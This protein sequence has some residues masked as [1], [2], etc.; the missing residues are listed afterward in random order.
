MWLIYVLDNSSIWGCLV[1]FNIGC[2]VW[3]QV[4]AVY[5]EMILSRCTP[6]RK[7]RAMLRSALKYMKQTLRWWMIWFESYHIAKF[8]CVLL[9][10]LD[11][12]RSHMKVRPKLYIDIFF[13][14]FSSLGS[15]R[16]VRP[17]PRIYT[18]K[19]EFKFHECQHLQT[20][21]F[22]YVWWFCRNQDLGWPSCNG[23]QPQGRSCSRVWEERDLPHPLNKH[24]NSWRNNPLH[25]NIIIV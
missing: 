9:I 24:E 22:L 5:E 23:I 16:K 13:S 12:V 10:M 21:L 20:F 19:H 17:K 1:Y 7:A 18:H 6:D 25:L 4:P 2:V 3:F 15:N 8:T 11:L 14:S